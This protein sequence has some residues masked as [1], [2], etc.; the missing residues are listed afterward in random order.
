MEARAQM[1][2]TDALA[3]TVG[4]Q[5]SFRITSRELDSLRCKEEKISTY[6]S[7][8]SLNTIH[9]DAKLLRHALDEAC[10]SVATLWRVPSLWVNYNV[11]ASPSM[12]MLNPRSCLAHSH[13]ASS[14][15]PFSHMLGLGFQSCIHANLKILVIVLCRSHIE[16]YP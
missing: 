6:Y 12:T 16:C 10:L 4:G 15:H 7:E 1:T 14:S 2:N 8:K 13:S 11:I 5:S 3:L 9:S